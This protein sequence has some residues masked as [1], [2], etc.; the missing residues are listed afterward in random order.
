MAFQYRFE[1]ILK[2]N[3]SEKKQL[4]QMY[5]ELFR[6]LEEQGKKL[7]E[8]MKRKELLI[9]Q[10]E[11]QK[12]AKMTVMGIRDHVH[13]LESIGTKIEAEQEKYNAIR[14]RLEKFKVTLMDKS[15]EL[16]KY[17]KLKSLHFA[18]Y[19]TQTKHIEAAQMDE[20]AIRGIYKQ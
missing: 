8:L 14:D 20:A 9:K 7:I 10:F 15:I 19:E 6:L 2:V 16:K 4:E 5:Q 13:I 1:R 18:Q 12:K 11:G 17:E 3:D